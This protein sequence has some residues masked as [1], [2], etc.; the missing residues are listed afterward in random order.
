MVV[1]VGMTML[2][3]VNLSMRLT[4]LANDTSSMPTEKYHGDNEIYDLIL[5]VRSVLCL[6]LTNVIHSGLITQCSWRT[7]TDLGFQKTDSDD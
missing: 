2:E 4:E 1:G 6:I 7:I 3:L 5:G